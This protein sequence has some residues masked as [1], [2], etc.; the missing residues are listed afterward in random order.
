MKVCLAFPME[1]P[2][3]TAGAC[4]VNLA[5]PVLW[6]DAAPGSSVQHVHPAELR[7]GA[8][9]EQRAGRLTRREQLGSVLAV[10]CPDHSPGL[11]QQRGLPGQ[12]SVC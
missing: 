1:L 11:C 4:K 10:R 7:C 3:G 5:G 9:S 12:R 8:V 2:F 6:Q